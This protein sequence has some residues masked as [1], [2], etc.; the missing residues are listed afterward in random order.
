MIKIAS[1]GHK[2]GQ[3]I[4][5]WYEKHFA[6][7]LLQKVAD[8]LN[9]YLDHR[10]KERECRGSKIIWEDYEGNKVDYD[11]VLE[12]GGTDDDLG[13]PVA[14]F[15]TFWRRG[16][17]HS[18]DKARDDS[19]KLMPIKSTYPT[20]RVLGVICAGD[21]T[22]PAKEYVLSRSIELFYTSKLQIVEAW[23]K[24]DLT[25]DY[26]DKLDEEEKQSLVGEV[27]SGL[28]SDN[29]LYS[30]IAGNLFHSIGQ[31]A[32]DAFVDRTAGKIGALPTEYKVMVKHLS[33]AFVFKTEIEIEKFI[34]SGEPRH[35]ELNYHTSYQY[36]VDFSDGDCY[37]CDGVG[38][39]EL[40]AMHQR[41]DILISHLR[42]IS[43]T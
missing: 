41:L 11:F 2:L 34:K 16:S 37:F 33:E 23:A 32:I 18:K 13:I 39:D 12:L 6:I 1:A 43:A 14:F 36:Q 28:E 19:G 35:I 20:V 26:P 40:I 3:I 17:K 21:F 15:E 31:S 30:R 24:E 29:N 25:I 38:W 7:P 42:N 22:T 9:L 8:K 4:G 5:D 10:F 27:V